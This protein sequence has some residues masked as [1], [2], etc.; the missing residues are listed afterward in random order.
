MLKVGDPVPEFALE[1]ES[2][3]VS[4]NDLKGRRYVLYFYPKDDT[5]GCTVEACEFRDNLPKFEKIAVPVFGVSAD[6]VKSHGKFAKKHG[7]NFTLLA[8]P[9]RKLIEPAGLWV[10]KSMYGKKYMGVQRSTFIVDENGKVAQVWEKVKPEGHA[11]EVLQWLGGAASSDPA[12]AAK[13]PAK[14]K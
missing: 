6:D 4:S 7:L 2:G 11:D 1:S 13:K 5:P 14:K 12:P 9:D 8:D 10:E 3:T